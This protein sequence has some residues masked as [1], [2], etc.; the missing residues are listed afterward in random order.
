MGCKTPLSPAIVSG[1]VSVISEHGKPSLRA[2]DAIDS[3]GK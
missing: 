2:Q 1:I 3:A